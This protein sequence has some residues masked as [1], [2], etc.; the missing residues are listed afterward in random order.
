MSNATANKGWLALVALA[1]AQFL[2][3]LDQSVMNVS[4]GALVHDF[5][6]T[7]TTIRRSS[8]STAW[9]WPCSS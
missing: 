9:S 2:M 6:T 8:P 1:T 4:I 5:H 3:V 7:V